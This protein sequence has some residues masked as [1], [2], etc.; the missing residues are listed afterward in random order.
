MTVPLRPA[1]PYFGSKLAVA[2]TLWEAFGDAPNLV[3]PFC[4]SA[5]VLLARRSPG[6]VETVNDAHAFIP[7]FLRAVR[8]EPE[9]VAEHAT[10]PVS[11]IDMHARHTALLERATGDFVEH[12]RADA[13]W[14]D[15]EVA[16]WWVW[17][18]SIWIGSGWCDP[19]HALKGGG[20][21]Q[22]QPRLRG[23]DGDAQQGVGVFRDSM[24]QQ[25]PHLGGGH[26][27][28]PAIAGGGARKV[29]R[30]E[31]QWAPGAGRAHSG[32]GI[33]RR[34]P[35]LAGPNNLGKLSAAA[36][37]AGEMGSPGVGYGRG[38]FATG[39][40]E[41]LAEYFRAI[42]DRLALVRIIC[43]D[44]R[45]VTT[46]AVT[47]SHGLTAVLLDPPYADAKRSA[48]LYA[49]D[50]MTVSADVREWAIEHGDKPQMRIALCGYEGEHAMPSSW[51]CYAWKTNGGYGNRSGENANASRERIWFSPNCLGG[52]RV[53]GPLFEAVG[54]GR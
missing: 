45:R 40:R 6:K 22:R 12:L 42:A 53:A 54:G 28:R 46:P 33:F 26:R 10:W 37:A 47:I 3:D 19:K 16:G 13:R 18:Q 9:L 14:Y 2:D 41:D 38:I 25:R 11:E 4:G 39:R 20:L 49:Q 34:L 43:G 48:K 23:R 8:A 44:W 27:K 35:H 17:G 36:L 51:R 24:S 52:E 31:G 50:S 1:Y 32:V 21:Q 15:A 7:N 30:L 5:S 29:P